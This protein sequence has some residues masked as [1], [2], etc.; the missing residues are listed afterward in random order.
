LPFRPGRQALDERDE[1][2]GGAQVGV[3]GLGDARV[4]DLDRDVAPARVVAR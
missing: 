3:D 4:L 1:R 2:A